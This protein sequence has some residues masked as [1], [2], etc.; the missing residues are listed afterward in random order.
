MINDYKTQSEWK[1]Q[2]IIAINFMSSK[3]TKSKMRTLYSKS[4]NIEITT[5]NETYKIIEAFFDSNLLRLRRINEKKR[6]CF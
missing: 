5:G 2:L 1:I 6:I 3:D 4:D